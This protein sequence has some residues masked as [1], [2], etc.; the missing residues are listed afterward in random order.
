[1]IRGRWKLVCLPLRQGCLLRLYDT[2]SDPDC[3][4]D[5]LAQEP[6]VAR[7]MAAA[8]RAFLERDGLADAAAAVLACLPGSAIESTA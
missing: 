6:E 4:H 1:V 7:E 3:L 5:R 8:L 2:R